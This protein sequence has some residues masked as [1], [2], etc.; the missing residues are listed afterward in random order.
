MEN[1][2]LGQATIFRRLLSILK[3]YG[4]KDSKRVP[5]ASLLLQLQETDLKSQGLTL[6]FPLVLIEQQILQKGAPEAEK[7]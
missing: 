7:L 1:N 4:M 5:V 3:I 2:S 6:V